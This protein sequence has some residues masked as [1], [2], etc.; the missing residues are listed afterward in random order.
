MRPTPLSSIDKIQEKRH[1]GF[2]GFSYHAPD[3][4]LRCR[5]RSPTERRY[6][7]AIL[8]V[9]DDIKRKQLGLKSLSLSIFRKILHARSNARSAHR[10]DVVPCA[11]RDVLKVPEPEHSRRETLE[12]TDTLCVVES[13][14]Q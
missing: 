6:Y 3:R 4:I 13:L 7:P 14:K 8:Q 2:L 11:W 12:F 1:Q 10:D 5:I 9:D